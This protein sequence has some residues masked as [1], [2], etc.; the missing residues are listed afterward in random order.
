[1]SKNCHCAVRHLH[2]LKST[3]PT[4]YN[5]TQLQRH[6]EQLEMLDTLKWQLRKITHHTPFNYQA[7]MAGGRWKDA[8]DIISF[9]EQQ[10]EATCTQVKALP[11]VLS[12]VAGTAPASG[13][14]LQF[15]ELELFE[16][17]PWHPA[18]RAAACAWGKA[19]M[20]SCWMGHLTPWRP[21]WFA[22]LCH[23]QHWPQSCPHGGC[24]VVGCR[25]NGVRLSPDGTQYVLVVSHHK[26]S[27]NSSV[28]D[29][30]PISYPFPPSLFVWLDVWF[31][32]CWPLVAAQGTTTMFCTFHQGVPLKSSG[33]T[34][35]FKG[36]VRVCP[37]FARHI[38]IT[39]RMSRGGAGP[40]HEP[41]AWSMGNSMY[42]WL[43]TYFPTFKLEQMKQSQLHMEHYR[44]QALEQ[45]GQAAADPLTLLAGAAPAALPALPAQQPQPAELGQQLEQMQQ[46]QQEFQAAVL[47]QLEQLRAAAP[48]VQPAAAQ[49]AAQLAAVKQEPVWPADTEWDD[50]TIDLTYSSSLDYDSASESMHTS[51]TLTLSILWLTQEEWINVLLW[52]VMPFFKGSRQLLRLTEPA[53]ARRAQPAVTADNCWLQH[54]CCVADSTAK[55]KKADLGT[56]CVFPAVK[57]LIRANL[58]EVAAAASSSTEVR[59]RRVKFS[60]SGGYWRLTFK[61]FGSHAI[62]LKTIDPKGGPIRWVAVREA[63]KEYTVH[64][65]LHVLLA[66]M[67]AGYR[68][69]FDEPFRALPGKISHV[70]AHLGE[71]RRGCCAP[72]HLGVVSPRHNV[73]TAH[74]FHK[75]KGKNIQDWKYGQA[76]PRMEANPEPAGPSAAAGVAASASLHSL[77]SLSAAEDRL[78]LALA[79]T[80][81]PIVTGKKPAT[82]PNRQRNHHGRLACVTNRPHL[83]GRTACK[84]SRR[85]T[86]HQLQHHP[87]TACPSHPGGSTHSLYGSPPARLPSSS[88]N[89][90]DTV[91]RHLLWAKLE[92]AGLQGWCLR[93]VQALYADVPVCVRTADGC[94]PMFQSQLGLKQGCPLSPNL[95]GLYVDDLPAAVAADAAADLPRLGDGSAVPSLMYADGLT[96]L[97]TS[98]SGLQHQMNKL[99]SYAAAWGLAINVQK[100]KMVVVHGQ[101]RTATPPD[102]AVPLTSSGATIEAVDEFRYLG[103]HFHGSLAFATAATA[104]AAAANRAMHAMRCRCAE[105]GLQGAKLQ[106]QMF[107]TMVL[108]VLS[109][110]AEVWSPQL[111]AAGSQCAATRVQTAFLRHLLG[112]RQS[113]PSLV[114]LA[115]TGQRPL[116]ARWAAQLG[117][118]WNTVL[119]ADE[120][121]LVMRALRDSCALA[122]EAGAAALPQQPWAGQVAAA[123]HAYGNENSCVQC[124]TG[125]AAADGMPGYLAALQHRAKW[126]ALA[127]LRTGSHWLAEETG[128]WQQQPRAE[129]LCSCCAAAGEQ[130]VEDVEH[131]VLAQLLAAALAAMGAQLDLNQPHPTCNEAVQSACNMCQLKQLHDAATCEAAS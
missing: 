12:G 13:L 107:N 66:Y 18:V 71:C 113:T 100:T 64:V 52:V 25:G 30:A 67:T 131:A 119:A 54:P 7:L 84:Q 99:D 112:V 37:K 35:L 1:M 19:L 128:R 69:P 103:I 117:R 17:H 118:F 111:I 3:S 114:L 109:Y 105:L 56:G 23:P 9:I 74:H 89:A 123:L 122:G 40:D 28:R 2:H 83:A 50:F 130:H 57:S 110:G 26:T 94:T 46:Q 85:V 91:P 93:A 70:A 5:A 58:E 27:D 62:L 120:T 76:S 44:H 32:W 63:I 14:P 124:A 129:R 78:R 116:M 31:K 125:A 6:T 86:R 73:M 77:A 108:P 104:R 92:A 8:P 43:T 88:L 10:K 11:G 42:Q 72:W 51:P 126:R 47:Q 95:F 15:P 65:S 61:V 41:A 79:P 20:L 53:A 80:V 81:G 96:C 21:E 102:A 59:D 34:T 4:P 90:Y 82:A 36:W 38:F 121:T 24:R 127:Q 29:R 48:A 49:P 55:K 39:D 115:E 97:A 98:P 33:I 75:N 68:D 16:T 87:H 60:Q 101:R 106:M 22:N 45:L